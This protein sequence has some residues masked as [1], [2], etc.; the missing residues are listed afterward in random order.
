MLFR[1]GKKSTHAVVGGTI[2][3]SATIAHAV[4]GGMSGTTEIRI[5][6]VV[7]VLVGIVLFHAWRQSQRADALTG[8]VAQMKAAQAAATSA[9]IAAAFQADA[10]EKA[11]ATEKVALDAARAAIGGPNDTGAAAIL[12]EAKR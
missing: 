2:I 5:L 6:V 12:T 8:A 7:A 10:K 3:G 9:K 1:S 11:I 4:H